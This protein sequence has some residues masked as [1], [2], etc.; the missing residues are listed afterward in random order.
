MYVVICCC[1]SFFLSFFSV[2]MYDLAYIMHNHVLFLLFFFLFS[3]IREVSCK[4][5]FKCPTHVQVPVCAYTSMCVC[6]CVCLVVSTVLC[7]C[8]GGAPLSPSFSNSLS[9]C[10]GWGQ[11]DAALHCTALPAN[12]NNNSKDTL[13]P[14]ADKSCLLRRCTAHSGLAKREREIKLIALSLSLSFIRSVAHL[15][16]RTCLGHF[17][18][19]WTLF[20]FTFSFSIVLPS[21]L[22]TLSLSLSSFT[23]LPTKAYYIEQC[24]AIYLFL[25]L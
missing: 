14:A 10:G 19:Q 25:Y 9:I 2:C 8:M 24:N 13:C 23:L 21:I 11:A 5:C 18:L 15:H 6:V 22:T 4:G 7:V 20:A 3:Y 12:N 1:F 16:T 17:Y